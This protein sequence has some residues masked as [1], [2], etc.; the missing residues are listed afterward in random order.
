M[1]KNQ[2]RNENCNGV[3]VQWVKQAGGR[4]ELVDWLL[5]PPVAALALYLIARWS[6][7]LPQAN[8]RR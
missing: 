1:Q 7:V 4:G 3:I 8:K 2:Y 6:G 5:I